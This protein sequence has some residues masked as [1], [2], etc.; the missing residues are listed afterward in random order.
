[1][2]IM[3]LP[4]HE[5]FVQ[6]N[7]ILVGVIPGPHEPSLHIRPLVDELKELWQGVVLKNCEGQMVVVRA[8]KGCFSN[9]FV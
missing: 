4:R 7:V 2:T 1:M 5:R 6:E 3:N 8:T 9:S